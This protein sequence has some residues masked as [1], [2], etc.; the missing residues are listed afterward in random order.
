MKKRERK[1]KT[2]EYNKGRIKEQNHRLKIKKDKRE[3][4]EREPNE[5]KQKREKLKKKNRA[6]S[7]VICVGP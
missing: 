5:K 7:T 4:D 1:E 2:K 6:R 3:R